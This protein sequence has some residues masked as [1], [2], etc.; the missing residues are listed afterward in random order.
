MSCQLARQQP[1]PEF[2][3][4]AQ[5]NPGA[6][7]ESSDGRGWEHL[8]VMR[9][10]ERSREACAPPLSNHTVILHL[11]EPLYLS[12]KLGSHSFDWLARHGETSIIPS[13][14]PTVWR[15]LNGDLGETLHMYLAPAFLEEVTDDYYG[16][17]RQQR[18][19]LEAAVGSSDPRAWHVGMLLKEE[20]G[21]AA[22][23]SRLY[24]DT[25]AIILAVSLLKRGEARTSSAV[26]TK[27][28]GLPKYRLRRATD[29]INDNL[30][31][32][33]RLK[34]I[35]QVVGMS[36]CHFARLFK[37]STGLAPHR[38]VIRQRLVE[39]KR[40]LIETEM[41]VANIAYRVGF[42]TQSRLS[43]TFKSEVGATPVQYRRDAR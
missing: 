6:L 41:T 11:N 17:A 8:S 26:E 18:A 42:S 38:F 9:F 3:S 22:P 21:C 43:I 32:D 14:T 27:K 30:T 33:L 20:L 23:S 34:D 2:M 4:Y 25:L 35:A 31:E 10:R 5:V 36:A 37:D 12:G 1:Q 7:V 15:C 24:S 13:G 39:A 40:L 29:F 28:G 19:G 16:E